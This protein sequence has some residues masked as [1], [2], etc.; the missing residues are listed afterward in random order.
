[1]RL[2]RV[3]YC[4]LLVLLCGA[5][6]H[7][8][9][10]I[11]V[12][13]TELP[14]PK[15]VDTASW[16]NMPADV[17]VSFANADTRYEKRNA[18]AVSQLETTWST[19]AW[20]GEKVHTQFLVWSTKLLGQVTI[21]KSALADKEGHSIPAENITTGFV[22]YVL[23]DGLNRQG[24]GCGIPGRSEMDSSLVEDVIDFEGVASIAA[25]TT[26]PVWLSI[27]V[28]RNTAAGVYYGTLQITMDGKEQPL[29]Y[30]IAVK[31]HLLPEPRDWA[32]HLDLW[33][34]PYA[35]A[36]VYNV[37]P[38]SAAHFEAM[39]PYIKMLADAGQKAITVSMVY[40]PWRG[41][42]QDIYG[43]MIQWVKKKNGTWYYDFSIFDSWVSFMMGYNIDKVINCYSMIPW[44]NKFYYYDETTGKDSVVEAKP[45]TP[46]YDAH[47]RP[48]LTA[49]KKHLKEKGWFGK[50]SIAMDERAVEDMQKTIALVKSVDKDFKV[51]LAGSYH[52]IIEKDIYDY[53]IASAESFDPDVMRRR[54]K[55]GL[56]TTFY[57]CCAE[58]FP[59]TFTFSPPAE[60]TWLGWYAA[61]KNFNGY[62]RW[63]YNCWNETPLT[64][65]RFRSWSA[66]DTYLVYPGPRSSI[67]FERMIEGIQDYEKIHVLQTTFSQNSQMEKLKQLQLM[68][69]NFNISALKDQAAGNMLQKAKAVLNAF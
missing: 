13:Y 49:F 57:T 46:A 61:A 6:L 25:K 37:K 63:A 19:T 59:N 22:R 54:L 40:D 51:S 66:G 50:T 44:N 18:P 1:M 52:T 60:S 7:A 4:V 55:A 64:D 12:N 39:K 53:C 8:Q 33:Q 31:D 10:K 16:N 21:K 14:D 62:L 68:L 9:N 29:H 32:F 23:T 69:A 3:V 2:N 42:T 47:W 26:Q 58:G 43:A 17:M 67:R 36:R 38:W 28:P 65:T 35:I 34:N 30:S 11:L 27:S 45:G 15:A 41:Q 56:P 5:Q 20:K 48:M 24:S